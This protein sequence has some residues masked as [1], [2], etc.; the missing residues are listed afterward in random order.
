MEQKL[1]ENPRRGQQLYEQAKKL[2]PGGTQLLS[3]RPEMFLPGQW[4]A[5]YAKALGAE[6]WDLDGKC[7][8]DCSI[9]GVT[10]STLGYADPDVETAVIEAVKEG[11]MSTLNCP[12]E[13]ELAELLIEL[14]PWA[15]MVRYARS[16]GEMMAVAARIA[17]VS[18]G[19]EKIAFCGYHGWHDWY[20]AANVAGNDALHDHLLPGLDCGGV[21]RGLK[22]T[23]L[24][25]SYNNIE[26]LQAIVAEHGKELA[27]IVMEP[28]R[29]E[30]P[31][32]GYLQEVRRLADRVGAVLV[33]DE[34][35]AGWKMNTGGI[36]L[37][38]G[39]EPDLAVFS[40][41]MANGF[42]MAAVIGRREVMAAA[43]STFISSTSWTER[44]GPAAA[45]A[46]IRKHRSENVPERLIQLGLKVRSGWEFA[47]KRVGLSVHTTGIPP[48]GCFSLDHPQAQ[49]LLTLYIQEMLDR[50]FLATGQFV[51]MFAHSDSQID[52]YLEAVDE[53]FALL[54]AAAEGDV[55][56]HLRGPVK[57]SGFR[58]L[59]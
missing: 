56:E 41:A 11:P 9:G 57:H 19:R 13:V 12:D 20:L 3:K 59:N 15:D 35:T 4:P 52:L 44:I 18:T 37:I 36:H 5:Y 31:L 54:A 7:Y 43:Q 29:S 58:R 51:P 14:P 6:V 42:A 49:E 2:I 47:A 23:M 50:G 53:V 28:E 22:G 48:L 55:V 17:R 46:T 25:F 32:E 38:Y 39:V 1:N 27:A 26:E 45:V 40:K 10:T 34:I 24:P 30:E 21:P 16:G 33:F 8:T